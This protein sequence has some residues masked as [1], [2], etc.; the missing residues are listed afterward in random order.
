MT[1]GSN[2][3]LASDREPQSTAPFGPV[4]NWLSHDPGDVREVII[5]KIADN[6]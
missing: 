5:S 4:R 1:V 2:D 6:Y 3:R